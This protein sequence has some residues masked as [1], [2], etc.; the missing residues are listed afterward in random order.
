M[1]SWAEG[2]VST[3]YDI[4]FGKLRRMRWVW[5]GRDEIGIWNF[6]QEARREEIT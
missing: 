2:P 3:L 6:A 4:L 1:L 5:H